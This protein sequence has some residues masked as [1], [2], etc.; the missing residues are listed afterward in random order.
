MLGVIYCDFTIAHCKLYNLTPLSNTCTVGGVRTYHEV[1]S[2]CGAAHCLSPI[3][4]KTGHFSEKSPPKYTV[5]TDTILNICGRYY[6]SDK[7]VAGLGNSF[8][9]STCYK[10][11][12]AYFTLYLLKIY[13]NEIDISYVWRHNCLHANALVQYSCTNFK[14]Q[15]LFT[16]FT[17]L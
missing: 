13:I 6:A 10:Y 12:L 14:M 5:S 8:K 4:T 17:W 3:I 11:T 1:M 2:S 15:P 7:P 16:L 9:K